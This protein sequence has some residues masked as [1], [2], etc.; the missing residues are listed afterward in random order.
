MLQLI[1]FDM[2]GVIVDTEYLD[3]Q[4]QSAYIKSLSANPEQLTHDD[5]SNLVGRSGT[6]LLMQIK[7]LSQTEL[8]F[9]EIEQGLADIEKEKY[10]AENYLPLFRSDITAILQYARGQGILLAV[11]SSTQKPYLL[12]IL[13]NC[14]IEEY[15]DLVVSGQDFPES[16]PNPAIYQSVLQKL[17]VPASKAVAVEDSPSGIEA[18]KGAG[19]YTIAYLEER[20]AV[21]QSQADILAKDMKEVLSHV[22]KRHL[23]TLTKNDF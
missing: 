20:M 21:D 22:R 10:Q 12:D 7:E 16:K 1:V 15:F 5:F 2:D 11:A 17:G 4:L 3:F 8:S 6:D 13:K 18:A 14:E 19:I 23:Q 9:D